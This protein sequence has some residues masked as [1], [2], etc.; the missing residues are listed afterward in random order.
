MS[1]LPASKAPEPIVIAFIGLGVMGAPMAGHLARAGHRVRV[2]NRTASKAQDWMAA[3][4]QVHDASVWG[5]PRLAAQGADMVISCV[6]ADRDLREVALG[7][8]GAYASLASG[9][10]WVDH[11]TTSAEVAQELAAEGQPRGIAFIDAPVSGGNLGAI[12]GTLTVMCGGDSTAFDRVKPVIQA[13]ARAV[14]LLGP[15]GSGQRA[16]MV[17]QICVAGVLQGLSEALAFGEKAGLDMAAVLEVIRQGAA[18]SWQM[19][20]RGPTMIQDRFDFGFAVDL[21]RKDLALCMQEARRVGARL[22]ST[23]LIDQ[24]YA[25]VQSLSQDG[26]SGGRWDTSSLIRLLR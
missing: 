3:V 24:F 12:N 21:M 22:P 25:E 1:A 19:E 23:A 10:V 16:K 11:S 20:H 17:N 18:Q 8:Q 26:Q 4:G 2:F 13:Y 6:G 7:E 5:S 9:A 15:V 14:T